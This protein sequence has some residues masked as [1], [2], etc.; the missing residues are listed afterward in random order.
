M[1]DILNGFI[2]DWSRKVDET[3][4]IVIKKVN[5]HIIMSGLF[6]ASLATYIIPNV[7]FSRQLLIPNHHKGVQ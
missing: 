4:I 2:N 5:K 7:T 1:Y 3:K 6:C